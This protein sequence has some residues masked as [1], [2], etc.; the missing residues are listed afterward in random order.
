LLL[1]QFSNTQIQKLKRAKA[2]GS[3]ETVQLFRDEFEFQEHIIDERDKETKNMLSK[4]TQIR[5]IMTDIAQ[6]TNEQRFLIDNIESNI[7]DASTR[8][9]KANQEIKKANTTQKKRTWFGL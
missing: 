2:C 4:M 6:I 8:V 9:E 7:E 5:E 3:F 1:L